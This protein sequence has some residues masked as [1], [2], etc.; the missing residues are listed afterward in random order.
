MRGLDEKERH[1]ELAQ[2]AIKESESV[3]RAAE[4]E[5]EKLVSAQNENQKQF[6]ELHEI[7]LSEHDNQV[8]AKDRLTGQIAELEGQL[9]EASLKNFSRLMQN[10]AG[11]A[12][13]PMENNV[14]TGCNTKLRMP[15]IYQLKAKG[16]VTCESCQR[17]LYLPQ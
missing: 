4:E 6:D 14:C 3:L 13:V 15:L 11:R 8:V 9:D 5:R 7:F 12:V 16:S 1:L 17:I 10:R 2:R